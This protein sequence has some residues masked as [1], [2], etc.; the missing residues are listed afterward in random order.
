MTG[1]NWARNI[2]FN[3]RSLARP[4]SVSDLQAVIAGNDRVRALGSGHSFNRIADTDGTQVTVADLPPEIEIDTTNRQVRV[5]AGLTYAQLAPRLEQVQLALPN[6]GSLPHIS[7]AGACATG[8]H[9]SGNGNGCLATR[10]SA[11][12]MVTASGEVVALSRAD[13]PDQFDGT[14]VA[15]GCLGVVTSMTLD[16]VP[17]FAVAQ[18]V[19][20]DLADENLDEHFDEI[21]ASGYSVSV[22]TDFRMNRLWCKRL[23]QDAPPGE[24]P[25]GATA[26]TEPRNPVPDVAAD[27]TTDQLG[28]PGPWHERLPHFRPEH[29][30]SSG[31]ELQ[32]EYLLPRRHAVVALRAVRVLRDQLT[33]VLQVAEVR[34]VAADDLWLSPCYRRDTVAFHFTWVD[35]TAAVLPVVRAL[36]QGLAPFQQR[37]HWGKVFDLP[38]ATV[39]HEYERMPAFLEL[40]REY[41]PHGK[42]SNAL[43]AKY[44]SLR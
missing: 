29:V 28:L 17:S 15:L 12:E 25:F 9:G 33:P 6:L 10:V 21:F 42:F 27:N 31:A 37:P 34:T 3:A 18:Y 20:D 35:D 4:T 38:P 19:F 22:F 2:V 30:P 13:D 44:L 11:I 14:V 32:S 26:A 36:E 8:T 5:S 39:A 40:M 24:S 43:V 7:I 41:D 16:L 23:A 1:T